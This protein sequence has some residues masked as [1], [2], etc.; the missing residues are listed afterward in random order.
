MKIKN[1][2][3]MISKDI[4]ESNYGF[5]ETDDGKLLQYT[6]EFE[7]GGSWDTPEEFIDQIK[8]DFENEFKQE[9]YPI[10]E[11]YLFDKITET[12]LKEYYREFVTE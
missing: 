8:Y 5:V 10:G 4:F 7:E 1:V 12:E 6:L 9:P 3:I 2:K 11:T